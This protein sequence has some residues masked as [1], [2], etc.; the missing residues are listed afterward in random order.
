MNILI[1]EDDAASREILARICRKSSEH[2]VT[3]AGDGRVAWELLDDANRWFDVVFL[4]VQMPEYGGLDILK[5]LKESPLHRSVETVMCTA[6]NDRST[7]VEA[8]GLGAKHYIV[9]PCKEEV[10]LAKLKQIIEKR[11]PDSR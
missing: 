9:K 4:D 7:I 6:S 11:A 1:A 3:L 5:R 2:R 10:V 8:I